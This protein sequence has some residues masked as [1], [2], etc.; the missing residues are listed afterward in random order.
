ME[1]VASQEGKWG[2]GCQ[3][4]ATPDSARAPPWVWTWADE[5]GEGGE[6]ASTR[7]GQGKLS[8]ENKVIRKAVCRERLLFKGVCVHRRKPLRGTCQ[9]MSKSAEQSVKGHSDTLLP[10]EKE[11]K[12]GC[13]PLA[14]RAALDKGKSR[15]GPPA[16]EALPSTP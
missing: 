10:P 4:S 14:G 2:H 3:V 11:R 15:A 16:A 1:L 8:L 6:A 9:R 7:P 5:A 12:Q 13:P